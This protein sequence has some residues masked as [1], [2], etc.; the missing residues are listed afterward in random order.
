MK[1]EF[2]CMSMFGYIYKITDKNG[3]VTYIELIER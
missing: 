3:K 2:V 1:Y